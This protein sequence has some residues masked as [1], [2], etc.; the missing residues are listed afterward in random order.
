MN[1]HIPRHISFVLDGNRR[2]AR[3]SNLSTLEGHLRGLDAVF[4]IIQWSQ[5]VGVEYLTTYAF[6]TENWNRTSEELGYLFGMVFEQGLK[7][8]LP[9]LI[10]NNVRVNLFGQLERFPQGMRVGVEDMLR[11]TAQNTGLVWNLCLDY[12]GR[13]EIVRAIKR[14]VIAGVPVEEI[15]EQ[16]VADQLY[17]AN[18]PDPDLMIRTGGEQRL[19]NFLLWQHAYTEFYYP[20]VGLPGFTRQDFDAALQWYA[21]RDRR[22]GK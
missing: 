6:S 18:M 8:Y 10:K 7:R 9:T 4:N 11:K 3:S 13:A 19:S 16:T 22:F 21:R 5:D 14:L 17:S 12:G 15:D 20:E 2:W 1:E